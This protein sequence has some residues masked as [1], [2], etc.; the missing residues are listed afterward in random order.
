MLAKWLDAKY[1]STKYVPVPIEEYLVHDGSIYPIS[2]TSTFFKTAGQLGSSQPLS[3][4]S[5]TR[6]I[7]PSKDQC[8]KNAVYNAVVS[9]ALETATAGYGALIFCGGRQGCQSMA[10]LISEAMPGSSVVDHNLLDKRKDVIS[11]LRSL[12]VGLDEVLGKTI[13]RGVAFHRLFPSSN[14]R[15]FSD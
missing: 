9:L 13:M 1:Y 2:T 10:A 15:I 7:S 5:P 4:I 6:I 12:S 8:L 3:K 11:E 14:G